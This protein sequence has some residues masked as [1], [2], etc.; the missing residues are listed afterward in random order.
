[1]L[2]HNHTLSDI[3]RYD[4]NK[5]LKT[6]LEETQDNIDYG[7]MFID[8]APHSYR[9][10][11]FL[12][13]HIPNIWEVVPNDEKHSLVYYAA[14]AVK[15]FDIASYWEMLIK[16]ME[17]D[18][19]KTP[20]EKQKDILIDM[21]FKASEYPIDIYLLNNFM[22]GILGEKVLE[23]IY[24]NNIKR[25]YHTHSH[26]SQSA[27]KN[28]SPENQLEVLKNTILKEDFFAT[29]FIMNNSQLS[30][31]E[32]VRLHIDNKPVLEYLQDRVDSY[33]AK[34]CNSM[35]AKNIEE[36][37]HYAVFVRKD[38]HI[39]DLVLNFYKLEKT[40]EKLSNLNLHKSLDKDLEKNI[41]KKIR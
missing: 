23:D 21:L 33:K 28:A 8:C 7:K 18:I 11:E 24:L 9:C 20:K 16:K 2:N 32:I 27:L 36:V 31:Q 6:C 10:F 14:Q 3:I 22:K 26:F 29:E 25:L 30:M 38:K 19:Q 12:I 5:E 35:S 39:H 13:Q 17:Q 37:F 40:V 15:K 1:M 34:I 41:G 4:R